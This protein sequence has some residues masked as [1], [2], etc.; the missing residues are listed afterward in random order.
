M[1]EQECGCNGEISGQH[2]D[3][4]PWIER[5]TDIGFCPMHAAAGDTL[6]ALERQ[7]DKAK[8]AWQFVS[9]VASDNHQ[10]QHNLGLGRTEPLYECA[11]S[12]CRNWCDDLQDYKDTITASETAIA[13]ARGGGA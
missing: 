8:W 1:A 7:R 13:A 9:A 11:E 6:A 10:R 5:T 12:I 2:L 4:E 3:G